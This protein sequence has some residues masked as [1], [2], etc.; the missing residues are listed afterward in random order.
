MKL[1]FLTRTEITGRVVGAFRAAEVE[2]EEAE[3]LV[4][5]G[6][7][8]PFG[9]KRAR[10]MPIP[11]VDKNRP[12]QEKITN[13]M[14]AKRVRDRVQEEMNQ[15]V[16][17]RFREFYA[18]TDPALSRATR[19]ATA[20]CLMRYEAYPYFA[21]EETIERD[22]VWKAALLHVPPRTFPD[23]IPIKTEYVKVRGARKKIETYLW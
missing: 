5:K 20:V 15:I 12:D 14:R 8:I 17:D 2:Q 16:Y 1:Y 6:D 9:E 7:A 21:K 22:A 4:A 3:R 11:Y 23:Y 10:P 19:V 18:K 13:R